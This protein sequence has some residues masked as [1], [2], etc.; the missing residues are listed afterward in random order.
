MNQSRIPTAI[1]SGLLISLFV[2]LNA[3]GAWATA[4]PAPQPRATADTHTVTLTPTHDNTLYEAELGR[5]SNGAGDHL[6]AGTTAKSEIRRGLVAFDLGSIPAGSTV[7][8]ATLTLTMS[9]TTAGDVVVGVHAA[10]AEWGEGESDAAGEEGAGALATPGDA[11]WLYR[12][13]DTAEW[14]QPGGDFAAVPSATA[15]VGGPGAYAWSSPGLAADVARWLAGGG[16]HG[17][18][19]VGD[20]AAPATAKRFDSRENAPAQRPRLVVTYAEPVGVVVVPV[21]VR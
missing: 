18:V 1:L 3:G 20:E 19:L 17:W 16:N 2:W 11:T 8:T 6:F 13:F 7:L 5:V 14:A 15:T 21:V 10:E 12:L 9:K 4:A